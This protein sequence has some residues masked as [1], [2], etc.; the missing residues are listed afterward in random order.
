MPPCD[1]VGGSADQGL[2]MPSP[3]SGVTTI[4]TVVPRCTMEPA[5][6]F[7]DLTYLSPR[8]Y[9]LNFGTKSAALILGAACAWVNPTTGGTVAGPGGSLLQRFMSSVISGVPDR[10]PGAPGGIVLSIACRRMNLQ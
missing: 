10:L 1:R 9:S 6:G 3:V 4:V 7:C 5:V 2:L 8:P